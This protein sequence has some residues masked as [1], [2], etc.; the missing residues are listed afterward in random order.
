MS[1]TE[2]TFT[3]IDGV[4]VYYDRGGSRRLGTFRST[5]SFY[6]KL[7]TWKREIEEYSREA[8]YGSLVHFV[9]AGAHVSKPGKHGE[10]EAFD[11]DEIRWSS[12]RTCRP[13]AGDHASSRTSRRKRYLAI[14]AIT[15]R[16]FRYTLDGWFDAA[17]RDHIHFDTSTTVRFAKGTSSDVKFMQAVCNNFAGTRLSIDGGWGPKTQAGFD[18]LMATAPLRGLNPTRS[19]ADYRRFG[20]IVAHYGLRDRR[21]DASTGGSQPIV[22]PLPRGGSV[23]SVR[24][25]QAML[26]DIGFPITVD[27]DLGPNTRQAV[28]WFQEA[29]TYD[30]LAIDGRMGSSTYTALSRCAANGGRISPHFRMKE[31]ASKG[32]GWPRMHRDMTRGLEKV[33]ARKGRALNLISAYRDPA[34][35]RRIGGA[36][37]SWHTKGRGADISTSYGLTVNQAKSLGVFTGIG[38]KPGTNLVK[39]LDTRTNRST[40][41][42]SVFAD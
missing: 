21:L 8:G 35:N 24:T 29:W 18:R 32:N 28:R 27:G 26:R 20:E 2:K 1:P 23:P 39:H 6:R 17:H 4:P 10:G 11:L 16:H 36:V 33:R 15:R 38:Y 3:H 13:I 9:S 12:G 31:M 22:P 40:S 25:Y 19:S 42:P 7:V 5:D 14:D 30:N 34:H 37:N 41:N